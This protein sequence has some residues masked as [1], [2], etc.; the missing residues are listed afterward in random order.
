MFLRERVVRGGRLWWWL[1]VGSESLEDSY[2]MVQVVQQLILVVVR[3]VRQ[4]L[5]LHV[6]LCNWVRL[7][8]RRST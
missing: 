3:W 6:V 8:G 1:L 4:V 7:F 5:I 2:P